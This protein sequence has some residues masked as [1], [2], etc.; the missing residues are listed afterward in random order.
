MK[1]CHSYNK[2]TM[3]QLDFLLRLSCNCKTKYPRHPRQT[4]QFCFSDCSF[5]KLF[6]VIID[7]RNIFCIETAGHF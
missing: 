7:F 6:F 4:V 2:K 1:D 3:L 5:I